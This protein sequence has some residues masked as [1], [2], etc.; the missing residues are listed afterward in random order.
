MSKH[1][2]SQQILERYSCITLS[3]LVLMIYEEYGDKCRYLNRFMQKLCNVPNIF[4]TDIHF[5]RCM[6]C[7]GS[8]DLAGICSV[9]LSNWIR[10]VVLNKIMMQ[11]TVYVFGLEPAS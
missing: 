9:S 2:D 10:I 6:Q 4:F 7:S 11:I 1:A 5:Y 8:A 3:P